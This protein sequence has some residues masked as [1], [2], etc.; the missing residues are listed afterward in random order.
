MPDD[1]AQRLAAVKARF[2]AKLETRLADIE[3]AVPLLEEAR[4]DLGTLLS[5]THRHV[6]DL[7]GIGPTLGFVATGR[8]ARVVERILLEPFR[9]ERPLSSPEMTRVREGLA[10]LRAAVAA[11]LALPE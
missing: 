10:A 6:H 3:K 11:D 2:A 4:P 7:C 8:A 9:T 1:F 5:D